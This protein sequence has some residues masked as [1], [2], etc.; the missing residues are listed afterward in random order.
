MAQQEQGVVKR[1]FFGFSVECDWPDTFPK[2]RLLRA[3][4]RHITLSFLGDCDY[5]RLE[6]LLPEVPRPPTGVFEGMFT[7]VLPFRSV[8][9]WEAEF[10]R[11]EP[12]FSYQCELEEWLV[13]HRFLKPT[14][15]QWLPH[16]T[17][18]RPPFD[19]RGWYAS[20]E[21]RRFSI[22]GCHLY[23]SVG[24]LLYDKINTM[25]S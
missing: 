18:A 6:G 21:A 3:E 7:R 10:D 15:K 11:P 5:G 25:S 23:E 16:T 1:L 19:R 17:L 8:I 22:T 14:K 20:F 13:E 12:L 4:D 2:G 9:A 24:G